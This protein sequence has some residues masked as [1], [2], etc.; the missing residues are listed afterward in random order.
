MSCKTKESTMKEHLKTVFKNIPQEWYSEIVDDVFITIYDRFYSY[1]KHSTK[2]EIT[3]LEKKEVFVNT[4]DNYVLSHYEN[5]GDFIDELSGESAIMENGEEYYLSHREEIE[6]YI[7]D[8]SSHITRRAIAHSLF[9]EEESSELYAYFQEYNLDIFHHITIPVEERLL[10][11]FN[12]KTHLPL[13]L[14]L[15]RT[16]DLKE[17]L[18]LKK[19]LQDVF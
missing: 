4:H 7:T 9:L 10:E 17:E 15:D 5:M 2:T 13:F 6:E 18:E 11:L 3:L 1:K 8:K 14:F 16:M 19:I 12:K